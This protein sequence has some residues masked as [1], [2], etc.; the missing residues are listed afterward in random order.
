[1]KIKHSK[2]KLSN[3][4]QGQKVTKISHAWLFVNILQ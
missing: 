3:H 4:K 1:M 2:N